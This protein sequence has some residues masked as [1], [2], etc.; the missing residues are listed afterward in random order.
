MLDS[1][2]VKATSTSAFFGEPSIIRVILEKMIPGALG[3]PREIMFIHRKVEEQPTAIAIEIHEAGSESARELIEYYLGQLIDNP[4]LTFAVRFTEVVDDT[5]IEGFEQI[6]ASAAARRALNLHFK[7]AVA[8]SEVTEVSEFGF[9][10]E[11]YFE[12]RVDELLAGGFDYENMS[13]GM[14][15]HK[16]ALVDDIMGIKRK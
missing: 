16:N 8:S 15:A 3:Q 7:A 2:V 1:I 4:K 13:E 9:E 5:G 12:T 11:E 10:S 6:T 14:L